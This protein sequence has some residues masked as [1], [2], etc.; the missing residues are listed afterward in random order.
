MSNTD[1]HPECHMRTALGNCDP[2]GGFCTSV[3]KEICEAL[4]N[5]YTNGKH[6]VEVS[7]DAISRTWVLNEIVTKVEDDDSLTDEQK[8][9]LSVAKYLIRHAPPVVPC[10]AEG[11]WIAKDGVFYCSCCD[12]DSAG[13]SEDDV[14]VYGIP[15]P[16]YCK[17]CGADMRGEK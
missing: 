2:I 15:L 16:H 6:S 7:E 5:A 8:D 9:S 12:N 4:Q 14:D 3:S 1:R 10:R 11:E 17:D 13:L